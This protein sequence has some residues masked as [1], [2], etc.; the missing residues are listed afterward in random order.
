M[1]DNP[2][3]QTSLFTKKT[4]DD[5]TV[6]Y[7]LENLDLDVTEVNTVFRTNA[8]S[9]DTIDEFLNNKKHIY[10]ISKYQKLNR[11]QRDKIY[12]IGAQDQNYYPVIADIYEHQKLDRDE[13]DRAIISG[14]NLDR[15][16]LGQELDYPQIDA[17]LEVT[18]TGDSDREYNKILQL[19]AALQIMSDDQL[20]H[21]LQYGNDEV[22]SCVY[23]YQKM[24]EE[25]IDLAIAI[26]NGD[27]KY[28]YGLQILSE[29]QINRAI[30]SDINYLSTVYETQ[31]LT[32]K[33][34]LAAIKK[35]QC[36]INTI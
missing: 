19:C 32:E 24:N 11:E 4:L 20:K 13:I 26:G 22:A 16:L 29:S 30:S 10:Q 23:K 28:L 15:L 5:E 33:Q 6:K 7:L 31:K 35:R 27:M 18:R 34:V 17:V 8:L 1:I 2:D 25:L 9:K 3:I 14:K 12:D 21:T 36:I